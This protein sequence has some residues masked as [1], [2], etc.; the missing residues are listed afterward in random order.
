MNTESQPYVHSLPLP[1]NDGPLEL[2][3]ESARWRAR[4][5]HFMSGSIERVLAELPTFELRDFKCSDN[6][7]A[8]PGLRSVVRIARTKFESDIPVG[9]VSNSYCLAQHQDVALTCLAGI[10]AAGVDPRGLKAEAGLTELGE[11]MNLRIY[12]PASFNRKRADAKEIAL[13]L[14]CFNSVDGSSR[15]V[16]LLGWIR[17]ICSNGM[18]IGET[19]AE[20]RDTHDDQLDLEPIIAAIVDGLQLVERDLAKMRQWEEVPI[21]AEAIRPWVDGKLSEAWGKKA[22]SRV[23]H[24]CQT[25]CETEFENPFE[26]GTASEKQVRLLHSV[27]G[28]RVPVQN[29]YDVSQSLS[30]VATRRRDPE[31]RLDWQYQIPGLIEN[32]HRVAK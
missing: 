24:L 12:F 31:N 7:P 9:I 25:G 21:T 10:A 26:K 22:A 5:V 14:E 20:L 15:L 16:V 8:N 6:G 28:A 1:S 13:R 30:W 32:L 27:P 23:F 4:D 11:W 18:V 19:K 2:L 17:W 29:L 3:D